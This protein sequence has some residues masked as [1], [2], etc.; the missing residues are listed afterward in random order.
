V[1]STHHEIAPGL[2]QDR[3][4]LITFGTANNPHKYN[5][6]GFA[7]W[8]EVLRAVPGSRFAFIRP[9]GGTPSFVANVQAQFQAHGI[10]PERIVFHTVRG[11]HMPFYNE[12]DITLDTAPL[13]GGTTTTEAL[14]MGAPVVSLIGEAFYERLSY[15]ILVNSGAA[16]LATDDRQ[17]YVEI[18][19]RLADDRARRTELRRSLRETMSNGPLGQDEQFAADF[20]EM[21]AQTLA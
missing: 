12:I 7:L 17:A 19:A 21:L 3:S 14:W 18:A 13:T 4:G 16:D 10:A 9:E 20:Y 11:R 8:S 1:F 2:P 15:S 5:R 6:A